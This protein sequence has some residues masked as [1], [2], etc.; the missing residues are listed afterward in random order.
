M[1][2]GTSMAA[3]HVAGTIALMFSIDPQLTADQIKTILTTTAMRDTF[4]ASVPSA[5]WGWGKLNAH[6]AVDTVVSQ[7]GP[8]PGAVPI[9][10]LVDNP[11]VREATFNYRLPEEATEASLHV[12]T[13]SGEAVL[14]AALPV[15]GNS[16]TWN[17]LDRAGRALADGLY[18]YI[19]TT[20]VGN[21]AVGRLV[22]SR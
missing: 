2:L 13:V 12:I 14:E 15:A 11:V 7:V 5:H 10:N 16:Y 6:D 18:L 8:P 19:I 9:V 20:D 1:N 17:L 21:S 22:I 3:P 4:T